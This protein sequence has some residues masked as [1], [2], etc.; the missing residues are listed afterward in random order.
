MDWLS[1][2]RLFPAVGVGVELPREFEASGVPFRER[3]RRTDEAIQ[4][5]GDAGAGRGD[6]PG[7]VLQARPHHVFPKPSGSPPPIWIGGKSEA[8]MKRTGRL[9]DGWM[10]SFITP[11]EIPGRRR[12][13]AGVGAEAGRDVPRDHFGT[14][15]N[16]YLDPD[17]AAARAM[18][19]PFIQRGR[20]D[21]ATIRAVHR[22]RAGRVRAASTRGVRRG[23][24]SKFILRPLCPSERMLDQLAQLAEEVVPEYHR[25][26]P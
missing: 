22:V 9:G 15:I 10:P 21:E 3:G 13:G 20:V 4:V 5:I 7:R 25:R 8:A 18:A 11:E 17:P 6:L 26:T 19:D 16:F 12:A 2:G 23:G 1:R 24:A 14:L